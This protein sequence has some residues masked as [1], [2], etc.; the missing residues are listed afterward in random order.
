MSR[1]PIAERWRTAVLRDRSIGDAAR[2]LALILVDEADE[3]GHVAVGRDELAR[4]LDRYPSRIAERVAELTASGYLQVVLRH[5]PSRPTTYAL[6][7]PGALSTV[8]HV[9]VSGPTRAVCVVNDTSGF[10]VRVD[11]GETQTERT[12]TSSRAVRV[13]IETPDQPNPW[14]TDANHLRTAAAQTKDAATENDDG[15]SELGRALAASR[16]NQ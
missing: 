5:A 15:L 9:R 6:V 10:A 1:T 8:E 2:V 11:S 3:R 7:L 13:P 12:N 4:R 16:R 14:A